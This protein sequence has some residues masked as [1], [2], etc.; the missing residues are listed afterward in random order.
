[1][2]RNNRVIFKD[3]TT[4][5]DLSIVLSDYL[6]QTYTIPITASED[7]IYLGS[8]MP[9]N[10]RWLEVSSANAAASAVSIYLWNGSEWIAAVDV[11]DETSVGGATLAQSGIISWVPDRENNGWVCE[12]STENISDL[13]TY[14]I[15]D[16]YWVKIVFSQN[17]T[18]TT[19]L[20]YVGHKFSIDP[21]LFAQYP[22]LEDHN[23]I[24]AFK[25]GK[26]DWK[27]Q[28]FE[29]AE[30]IIEDLRKNGTIYSKNQLLDW[31]LL[32]NAS[33]HKVAEIIFRAFGDDYRDNK[34]LASQDYKSAVAIKGMSVDRNYNAKLDPIEKRRTTDHLTR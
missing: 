6:S 32:K 22:E 3:N 34:V 16:M 7:A 30:Y 4:R 13:S 14:K 5:Y 27:D 19:A 31:R 18:S 23:V 9:F 20:K 24:T 11:V 28:S 2:L 10:H 17:L 8:D 21:D 1:M 26:L 15:Y 29:A 33:V 25:S 12:Q